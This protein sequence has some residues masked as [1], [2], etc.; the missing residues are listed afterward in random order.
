MSNEIIQNTS[1]Q[2][3][4]EAIEKRA[5]VI[6]ILIDAKNI[7]KAKDARF[8]PKG[9]NDKSVVHVANWIIE[10]LPLAGLAG[11]EPELAERIYYD[12][13]NPSRIDCFV[14]LGGRI[15]RIK[16]EEMKGEK[17]NKDLL[18]KLKEFVS[19]DDINNPRICF[20]EVLG[21][22]EF[23]AFIKRLEGDE[24]DLLNKKNS[25]KEYLD[26]L[27]KIK[28]YNKEKLF[29]EAINDSSPW[30]KKNEKNKNG[31]QWKELED[32]LEEHWKEYLEKEELKKYLESKKSSEVVKDEVVKELF[33]LA[34]KQT[35]EHY[36]K[37]YTEYKKY[38]ST[39]KEEK[40]EI[41]VPVLAFGKFIGV[42]NFHRNY[43]FK[44]DEG[45][46]A[47]IYAARLAA[48]YL[49]WQGIL[50]KNFQDVAQTISAENNFEL[51]GSEITKGIR[52]GLQHGLE[53]DKVF[54]LLYVSNRPIR[55]SEN[56]NE[57]EFKTMW[58]YQPRLKPIDNKGINLWEEEKN[59]GE[60]PIRG[61][62]LGST[63]IKKWQM[64][65]KSK[66]K[67]EAKDRFVVCP[68]VDNLDSTCRSISAHYHEIK[69]TGCILLTFENKVNGLLYLHCKERHYFTEAELNALNTLGVQAAIAIHNAELTGYTYEKL[70]GDKLLEQLRYLFRWDKIPGNDDGI[71]LEFL[72]QNFGIDWKN[73]PKIEKIGG[74]TVKVST[75]KNL[76]SLKI[77]DEK[78]KL[79][80]E[81]D[82]GRTDEL[83]AKVENDKLNIYRGK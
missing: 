57:A 10:E 37:L 6:D 24:E 32:Y 67:P 1:I 81:I 35:L 29:Y 49:Q 69:T 56:I 62:G 13:D 60:I 22:P 42:L 53:E 23:D 18:Q 73:T 43:E 78:T 2:T 44:E 77:N 66:E 19:E 54:P 31:K 64:K 40:Y 5:E 30:I 74:K 58:R 4:I 28:S 27:N 50:F 14:G 48:T 41:V 15:G 55:Y 75:E 9:W 72:K 16:E 12:S 51:I 7:L 17:G 33:L 59:L 21:V 52:I 68:Y 3:L 80:I 82:D 38:I 8:R 36:N 25:W 11:F 83:I 71:L 45:N 47:K 65:M 26:Y 76:L 46:L 34:A 79:N 20:H 61:R 70:Y 63:V 39:A